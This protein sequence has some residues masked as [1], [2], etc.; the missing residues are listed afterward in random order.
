METV[1]LL[2]S[3]VSILLV[4]LVARTFSLSSKFRELETRLKA[5]ERRSSETLVASSPGIAP[6]PLVTPDRAVPPSIAPPEAVRESAVPTVAAKL[7]VAA[8][9]ETAAVPAAPSRNREEWEAL[10]G[11]KLLNRIGALALI[12]GVGFFL[13]HAFDND[14]IGETTRVLIGAA[15]GFICLIGAG[16]TAKKG[17]QIFSQGIV[18]AGIAILYL[19]VYASFNFYQLVSQPVAFGLMA[20]V[21]VI[22]FLEAFRYNSIAV[23]LLATVGGFLTPFMLNTGES[24]EPGLFTYVVLLD[25]GVIFILLRKNSWIVLEPLSL[26]GTYI[27]YFSWFSTYYTPPETLLTLIFLA[28]FWAIFHGLDMFRVI[29]APASFAEVR[30]VVAALHA[31]LFFGTLFSLINPHFHSQMGI[32]AAVASAFYFGSAVPLE[33]RRPGADSAL[34]QYTLTAVIFLALAAAIEFER[35]TITMF[36]TAEA[37]IL[38]WAG[39]RNQRRYLWT[40]GLVLFGVTALTLLAL[41]GSL[42]ASSLEEFRPLLNPRALAYIFLAASICASVYLVR[43]VTHSGSTVLAEVLHYGWILLVFTLLTVETNDLFRSWMINATDKQMESLG[44]ARFMVMAVVWSL[45]ALVLVWVA[46]RADIRPVIFSGISLAFLGACLAGLRGIAFDPLTAFTPLFNIR[47]YTI[48]LIAAVMFLESRWLRNSLVRSAWIPELR[49][50]MLI[51]SVALLLVLFTGETRDTFEQPLSALAASTVK[52]SLEEAARLENLKQLSL[53]GVWL[54]FSIV[55]MAFGIWRRTR[56]LRLMAMVLFGVTILKI[57]IYDLSFLDTLYRIFSFVALGLIL[58]AV[59]Y[60]YQRY[61]AIIL[62]PSDTKIA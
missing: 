51:V 8:P 32:A 6:P 56:I 13:K 18:G 44:F 40:A 1:G 5:L 47:V 12:I 29:T 55:V 58:L 53:S 38:I 7:F 45:Y 25:L 39:V 31:P 37:T 19:S 2:V 28:L 61:R 23:S 27:I 10:I 24:N 48:L 59:S 34:T 43:N 16:R 50:A 26:V 49:E 20:A 21:T 36:W 41:R 42:A 15:A 22:A 30:R 9:P 62:G 46:R 57:F 35:F 52:G 11:G 17:F 60:L 54:V 4:V 3:I 33:R 14:W